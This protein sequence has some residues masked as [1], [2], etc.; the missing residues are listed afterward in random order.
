MIRP[1]AFARA[2]RDKQDVRFLRD[3]NPSILFGRTKS[4][5]LQLSDTPD[6][7]AF[8]AEMP[9]TPEARSAKVSVE[10]GDIDGCS[11]AFVPTAVEWRSDGD[12]TVREIV[13][14][15]LYD[16]SIVTYPAYA[17]GTSVD[18]RSIQPVQP[19]SHEAKYR[20]WSMLEKI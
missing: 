16:V 12:M 15:D 3:H 1:G 20:L 5:T 18:L 14:V 19:I 6:G 2:I 10:R 8:E 13:D 11:F 4:G 17:T 7:L 9:D